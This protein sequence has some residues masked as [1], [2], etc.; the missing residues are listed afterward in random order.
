MPTLSADRRAWYIYI[1]A[2]EEKV[3]N[4]DAEKDLGV[5]YRFR[6]FAI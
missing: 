4:A 1:L 5:D 6:R 3:Q 2:P